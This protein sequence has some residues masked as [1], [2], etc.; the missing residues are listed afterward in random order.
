MKIAI[1]TF[2]KTIGL[3]KVKTRLAKTIGDENAEAFYRLSVLA[4]REVLQKTQEQ[5]P[6]I[7]PHWALAEE[8]AVELEQW[9]SFPNLWTGEGG[10]GTR[11]SNISSTLLNDYEIVFLMGTDSPQISPKRLL[12]ITQMMEVNSEIEQAVG[13][14]SDGG[15][16][17][18]GSKK[19]LPKSVWENVTYSVDTTLEELIAQAL[20]HVNLV[21]KT[22]RMRDVDELDDLK[23]LHE[24]LEH[25]GATLLPA[26]VKLL[27]WLQANNPT[28][29]G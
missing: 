29:Q 18:W 20:K 26:Q 11:L 7:V 21:Y 2:A 23:M 3:S 24:T 1:A 22:Y 25:R 19:P 28:F 15:F 9:K 10:L 14:A 12:Q 6:N 16:W 17:L 8:E 5:N 13:P 4:V 27:E